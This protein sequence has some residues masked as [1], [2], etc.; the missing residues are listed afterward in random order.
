MANQVKPLKKYGQ[1]FL[2]NENYADKIVDS[3]ECQQDDIIIE[4]G[5][6]NGVLTKRLINKK[7]L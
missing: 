5:P 1:N 6:G 3:L 4:I 2:L 7:T